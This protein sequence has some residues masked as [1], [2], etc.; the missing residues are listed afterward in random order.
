MASIKDKA[1]KILIAPRITEKSATVGSTGSGLVFDV[2]PKANKIEI[3]HAIEE[4]FDVKV[5]KI[6]T[7][8]CP[9]PG[10]NRRGN[11]LS[12]KGAYKK[13]YV[14]LREGNSLD[15]IEGL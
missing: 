7:V 13:A 6:R 1:Y 3:K 10:K 5:G 15:I 4:V 12:S 8:N 11:L 2:H 14:T 9:K